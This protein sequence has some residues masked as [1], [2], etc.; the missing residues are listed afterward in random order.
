MAAKFFSSALGCSTAKIVAS[1][2]SSR[3][4]ICGARNLIG[5]RAKFI[6]RFLTSSVQSMQAYVEESARNDG[7]KPQRARPGTLKAVLLDGQTLKILALRY[8]LT[9]Q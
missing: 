9:E 2:C 5:C 1:V 3:A 7:R 6:T 8:G 4:Y